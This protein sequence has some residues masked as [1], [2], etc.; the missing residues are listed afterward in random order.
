MEKEALLKKRDELEKN[1]KAMEANFHQLSG[2]I[3]LINEQIASFDAPKV[4]K[5]EG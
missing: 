2:A 1:R 5:K 4:E 3:A